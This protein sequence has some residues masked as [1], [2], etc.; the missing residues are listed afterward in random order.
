MRPWLVLSPTSP[1][2]DAGMRI[3]PPPSLACAI[4]TMPAA[5]AAADPP[6]EPPGEWSGFQGFLVIPNA[7]GSVLGRLPHSGLAP[8]PTID[9][10]AVSK[11]STSQVFSVE[12]CA[13]A[14][15]ARLPF[16]IGW[17]A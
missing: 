14:L 12:T 2:H 16:V 9:R 4:G 8:R 6:D 5:T 15:S 10:P 13:A 1:Q 3:E 17:P 7:S 11:R